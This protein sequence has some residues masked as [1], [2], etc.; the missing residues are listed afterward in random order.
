MEN[1]Q[2]NSA[3]HRAW[4]TTEP[5]KTQHK[6]IAYH[7]HSRHE[8]SMPSVC[9]SYHAAYNHGR[10]SAHNSPCQTATQSGL[11]TS[12]AFP[13]SDY[14]RSKAFTNLFLSSDHTTE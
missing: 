13:Q 6:M 5:E 9:K 11:D 3:S 10:I 1:P 8:N 4:G 12:H 14:D 2:G 7:P